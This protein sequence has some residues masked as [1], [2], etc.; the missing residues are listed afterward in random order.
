MRVCS[1]FCMG[2]CLPDKGA[3][4]IF[5]EG[6][7]LLRGYDIEW[8]DANDRSCSESCGPQQ[9]IRT[10]EKVSV[11]RKSQGRSSPQ[12]DAFEKANSH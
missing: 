2:G 9:L 8:G 11:Q 12:R 4:A 1:D 10:Q 6:P 7:Y 3:P 5:A